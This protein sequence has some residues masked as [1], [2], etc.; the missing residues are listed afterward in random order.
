ML[1][2]LGVAGP[3]LAGNIVAIVVSAAVCIIW[4]LVKPDRDAT[5]EDL[6]DKLQE[7]IQVLDDVKVGCLTRSLIMSLPPKWFSKEFL[8][9]SP[10]STM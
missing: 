3:S 7:K 10:W 9:L 6:R 2:A 4:T 1:Q 8:C 5:W